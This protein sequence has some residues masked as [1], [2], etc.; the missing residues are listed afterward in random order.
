MALDW[1]VR[2]RS[3]EATERDA[4]AFRAWRSGSEENEAAIRSAVSLWNRV[5]PAAAAVRASDAADNVLVLKKVRREETKTHFSPSRRVFLGGAIAAS[6][7]YFMVRPPFEL[8]P[9]LEELSASYRTAKGEQREVQV[10]EQVTIELNTQTSVNL[11]SAGQAPH[12]EL[13][14]GEVV[15]KSALPPDALVKVTAFDGTISASTSHFAAKCIE[16]QVTVTC[17]EGFVTV[18]RGERN[19][20]LLPSQQVSFSNVGLGQSLV[21]DQGIETA[22]RSGLLVF[23]NRPLADVIAEVNRYRSGRIILVRRDLASRLVNGSF[24]LDNLDEVIRQIRQIYQVDV[25]RL[26]GGIVMLS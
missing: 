2:L 18:D 10:S 4:A 22:W 17:L 9:S 20:T 3:G 19:V 8:W 26:P 14:S 5:G 6:A 12:L 16:D 13:L 24:H 25:T 23:N 11:V 21:I 15:V 1:V 7:A